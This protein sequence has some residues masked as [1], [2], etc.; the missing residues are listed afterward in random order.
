MS[1]PSH[2]QL[3]NFVQWCVA[4]ARSIAMMP[5]GEARDARQKS[6][7]VRSG[8]F[9]KLPPD[10]KLEAIDGAQISAPTQGVPDAK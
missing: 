1:Q 6:F 5:A 4:E 8:A 10:T 3:K 9:D 2:E 7:E